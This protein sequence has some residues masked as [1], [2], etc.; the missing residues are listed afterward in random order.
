MLVAL[1]IDTSAKITQIYSGGA[2]NFIVTENHED[3]KNSENE[4]S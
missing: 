1:D 4:K 2:H 3:N